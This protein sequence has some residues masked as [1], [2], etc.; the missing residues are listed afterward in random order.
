MKFRIA[1]IAF[2][3]SSLSIGIAWLTL[4]P[5]FLRLVSELRKLAPAT[6]PESELLKHF[7][8]LLPVY[9]GLNLLLLTVICYF[10]LYLM[11][12]RPLRRTEDAIEQLGRL[13]LEMPWETQG[14]PLL[15]R[16][17]AALKRMAQAL[18]REQATTRRQLSELT[19]ANERLTRA[20][21]E[22]VSA[23]RLATVG[24]L[25]AGVAHEIGNPL[26]GVLGYLSLARSYGGSSPKL[27]ECLE[28]IDSEVHRIDR[29]VRGLLDL[30]R[31]PQGA[32]GP[33]DVAALVE[34]CVRL[35]SAG[36]DFRQVKVQLL[37][38]PGAIARA[39]SGPLSQVMI[40]LLL[41][42]AQAIQGEGNVTVRSSRSGGQVLVQVEDSGTGI[43]VAI[44]PRLFEPF[45][46]TKGTRGS[47]LGLAVSLHLV[48]SM[49]GQLTADDLDGG[50]A[51]FTVGL[52]AA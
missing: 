12:G 23:A 6:S 20:Q 9:F 33:V 22:L 43:P 16:V 46:T 39:E 34:T 35:V 40:N 50:G 2:L 48:S 47:G 21:T 15:A 44:R 18:Q 41:N 19:T 25:A 24:E 32:A 52:P 8:A 26:A 38:E 14:G 1:S 17:Q 37:L 42:A 30:G 3:F 11:V 49:G 27:R 13:E 45:F 7:R 36:P 29:I 4:Q 31:P 28:S 5:V 10:V 51:R